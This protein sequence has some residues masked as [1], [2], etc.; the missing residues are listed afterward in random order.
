MNAIV[1]EKEKLEEEEEKKREIREAISYP[2]LPLT[3]K[4]E[5]RLY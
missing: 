4:N 1:E 3:K 2:N 5:V